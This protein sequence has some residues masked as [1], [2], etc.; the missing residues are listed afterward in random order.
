M[1]KVDGLQGRGEAPG[2]V[3]ETGGSRET[4]KSHVR[5]DFGGGKGATETGIRQAWCEQGSGEGGG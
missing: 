1:S 4:A 3:V 5:S 2:A